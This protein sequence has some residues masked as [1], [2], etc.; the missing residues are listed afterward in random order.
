MIKL[1]F[2]GWLAG[3]LLAIVSGLLG[4]FIIWR[5]M[6]Y[7]GDTL[8]H[9]SL[10]G[11]AFGLL[12]QINLFYSVILITIIV[13]MLLTWLE[14]Y[15]QLSIDTLLGIMAHSTLS[16]GLVIISLIENIRMDLITYLF[17]DLLSVTNEDIFLIAVGITIVCTILIWQWRNLVSITI[18]Q[19]LAFI[20]GVKIQKLKALL[21]LVTAIT[22][23]IAIKFVGAL[24]ITS[25][26]II[27]SATGRQFAKTPEQMAVISIIIAMFSVTGGLLISA[28]YDTPTGPSVVICASSLFILSLLFKIKN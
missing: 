5:R 1:L 28:Y 25:L 3:M 14:K 18:N 11:I 26:F 6:S 23:G 2:P 20:D 9:A 16:I 17:G 19:D 7:F 4:S 10:V 12:F 27:P 24:I 21:M 8:A 15:P 13:A 22:I